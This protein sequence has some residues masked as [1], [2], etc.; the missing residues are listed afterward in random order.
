MSQAR[1]SVRAVSRLFCL[2]GQQPLKCGALVPKHFDGNARPNKSKAQDATLLD[3]LDFKRPH[4]LRRQFPSITDPISLPRDRS[5]TSRN[6]ANENT[7]PAA[8]PL[9]RGPATLSV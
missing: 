9:S 1:L 3:Y 5:M 8:Q 4:L 6:T 7:C 2:G